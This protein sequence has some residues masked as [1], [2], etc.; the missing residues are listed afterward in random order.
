MNSSTRNQTI[1]FYLTKEQ[2]ITF[3]GSSILID[4]INLYFLTPLSLIGAVLNLLSF[5]VFSQKDFSSI[6]LCSYLKILTLNSL[7]VNLLQSTVFFFTN[8]RFFEFT[9]TV[10]MVN[11]YSYFYFPFIS[12]TYT[13]GNIIAI[14]INLERIFQAKKRADYFKKLNSKVVGLVLFVVCILLN[15]PLFLTYTP[16][17]KQLPIGPSSF[18]TVHYN[19]YT[20]FSTGLFGKI[21][22]YIL[23]GLRNI[24]IYLIEIVV[25]VVLVL[26]LKSFLKKKQQLTGKFYSNKISF[27]GSIEQ[28]NAKNY[29][30]SKKLEFK[31]TVMV[32]I[33]CLLSTLEH[34]FYIA[35]TLYILFNFDFVTN[36]LFVVS[37]FLITF[38]HFF[39]IVLFCVFNKVFR[40]NIRSLIFEK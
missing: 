21:T 13:F 12:V 19:T 26:S 40:K 34:S 18:F 20:Q 29:T 25:N 32:L 39:N 24:V 2:W 16:S 7:A 1:V 15:I 3:F 27:N 35:Y 30:K 11:Y 23:Y 36:V 4:Q 38:K 8:Y 22:T 33:I 6:N 9:N 28:S 10:Q 17:N 5:I 31:S 14:I 37:N